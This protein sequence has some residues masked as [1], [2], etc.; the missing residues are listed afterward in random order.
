LNYLKEHER[1]TEAIVITGYATI[2]NARA[3]EFLSAQ[4]VSKPFELKQIAKM[5][6]KAAKKFR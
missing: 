5:V 1:D 3:A 4:F 2:E 6:N